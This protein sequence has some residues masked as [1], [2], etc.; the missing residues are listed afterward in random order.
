MSYLLPPTSLLPGLSESEKIEVLDHLFEP[1]AT[2]QGV[3]LP[4]IFQAKYGSYPE[5]IETARE[6][7]LSF[8]KHNSEDP[9]ISKIIAAHPRLGAPKQGKP[10][11]EL[12]EHSSAEQKSLQGSPEEQAKLADLNEKY[13]LT[14]PGLR[15]VV[16]VNGRS[17]PVVMDNM[18][19][20]IQR[21]D[22][23]LERIEAFNAM[24]DIALD[25]ASKLATSPKL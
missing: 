17:R 9:R 19:E 13:E 1:C 15:Y 2:L 3:L 22:I 5:F 11:E 23:N 20:R 12:S 10:K 16:F 8:L 4:K 6:E 25:R 18:I 24:C 14:F 21:N 7:L